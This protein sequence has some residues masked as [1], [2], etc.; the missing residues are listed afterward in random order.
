MIVLSFFVPSH[1]AVLISTIIVAT[2]GVVTDK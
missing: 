2:I 1:V